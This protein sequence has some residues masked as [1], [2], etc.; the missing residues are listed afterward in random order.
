MP[1]S[2]LSEMS[3]TEREQ[4]LNLLAAADPNALSFEATQEGSII[5]TLLIP[6]SGQGHEKEAE[7]STVAA[8]IRGSSANTTSSGL[9]NTPLYKEPSLELVKGETKSVKW[10]FKLIE[11]IWSQRCKAITEGGDSQDNLYKFTFHY[12]TQKFGLGTIV[13]NTLSDLLYNAHRYAFISTACEMFLAFLKEGAMTDLDL[14]FFVIARSHFTN[15]CL[16]EVRSVEGNDGNKYQVPRRFVPLR[17][18]PMLLKKVLYKHP[19]AAHVRSLVATWLEIGPTPSNKRAFQKPGYVDCYELLRYMLSVYGEVPKVMVRLQRPM[20]ESHTDRQYYKQQLPEPTQLSFTENTSYNIMANDGNLSL[21]ELPSQVSMPVDDIQLPLVSDPTPTPMSMPAPDP[22]MPA[23]YD[24]PETKPFVADTSC[25]TVSSYEGSRKAASDRPL[26]D[27]S[28]Q[29]SSLDDVE[30]EQKMQRLDQEVQN[31]RRLQ[32]KL[33]TAG[34]Q[35]PPRQASTTGYQ[36]PSRQASATGCQSPP[37]QVSAAGY[38]SPL[39]QVSSVKRASPPKPV[40]SAV[41]LQSPS[42]RDSPLREARQVKSIFSQQ[43]DSEEMDSV[44]AALLGEGG[45]TL[46]QQEANNAAATVQA[47]A[48]DKVSD[49]SS[50]SPL[51]D[52]MTKEERSFYNSL[53]AA[54]E[55]GQGR[56]VPDLIDEDDLEFQPDEASFRSS[57]TDGITSLELLAMSDS[58]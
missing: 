47:D 48:D 8:S 50:A 12:F 18:L 57:H 1:Y 56:Q 15:H 23:T 36:S 44:P 38:Q 34:Y 20:P 3:P 27:E 19:H 51:L 4:I 49:V 37:R 52:A 26:L 42:V 58:F 43:C 14:R 6:T 2:S 46:D 24:V 21:A 41:S 9:A 7:L 55:R 13:E 33:G 11:D 45:I 54:L 35:S 29:Q 28:L 40:A 5:A 31:L 39:R 32:E 22:V 17:A 30:L 10:T 16:T 53:S 25:C